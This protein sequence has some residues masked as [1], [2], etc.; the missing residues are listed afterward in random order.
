M[1]NLPQELYNE[2]FKGTD[3]SNLLS[4]SL[5]CKAWL[6]STRQSPLFQNISMTNSNADAFADLVMNSNSSFPFCIQE[7]TLD[8]NATWLRRLLPFLQSS[9][10]QSLRISNI[11]WSKIDEH[12][13]SQFISYF[14]TTVQKLAIG[15]AVAFEDLVGATRLINQFSSLKA[16]SMKDVQWSR[17]RAKIDSNSRHS[18]VHNKTLQSNPNYTTFPFY[19]LPADCRSLHFTQCDL[20]DLSDWLHAHKPFP[21]VPKLHLEDAKLPEL[22]HLRAIYINASPVVEE[23][24][25]SFDVTAGPIGDFNCAIEVVY[26][27]ESR[28][29]DL[30]PR[31]R[32]PKQVMER[33]KGYC[34]ED[35]IN[36]F[37]P[38]LV[39]LRFDNF[40]YFS[41]KD[42]S[43]GVFYALHAL[44]F[45][46]CRKN[47][48]PLRQV[49][50][51]IMLHRAGDLDRHVIDWPLLDIALLQLADFA[52]VGGEEYRVDGSETGFRIIFEIGGGANVEAVTALIQVKLPQSHIESIVEFKEVTVG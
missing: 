15:P 37:L 9:N 32:I 50:C 16:L 7:L 36:Y 5:V 3:N 34:P 25:L 12:T 11:D 41:S 19:P 20:S 48:T 22:T 44:T 23:L 43:C 33:V 40:V 27:R 14:P 8:V 6:P 26:E 30:V 39:K 1:S 51:G 45:L 49:I 13:Q 52:R 29:K 2:I 17:V 4:C 21:N 31:L 10:I 28:G 38:S 42:R 46:A 47:C 35:R 24:W 18:T